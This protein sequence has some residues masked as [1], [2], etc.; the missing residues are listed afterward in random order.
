[1]LDYDSARSKMNKLINKPSEDPTKLP[2]VR[3]CNIQ[4]AIFRRF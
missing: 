3:A 2:R 4:H 1:M